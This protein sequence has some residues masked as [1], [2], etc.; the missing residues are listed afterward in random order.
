M[1]ERRIPWNKGLKGVYKHS[2]ENRKFLGDI[3]K[4]VGEKT[5]FQKGI[6]VSPSTQFKKGQLARLG[7]KHTDA[8]KEKIRQSNLKNPRRYWLGK[9]NPYQRGENNVNWNGGISTE[10]EKARGTIEYREWRRKVFERDRF[11][12]RVCRARGYVQANHIQPFRNHK[13]LRT[14]ILNGIT[15]CIPCHKFIF[16]REHLFIGL[17]QGILEN[18]LNSAE[19]SQETT[20]SQ[21][22]RLR[23]ALW[24]CVTVSGE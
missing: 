1:K 23:K 17:F 16:K 11:I 5:R 8:T 21:Q 10:N 20:P 14:N 3:L 13:E 2:P 24:A 15:L 19:L 18:G 12:C 9:Q 7:K 6:S 4:K 22:E